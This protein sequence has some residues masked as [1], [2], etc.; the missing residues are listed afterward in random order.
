MDVYYLSR[1][2]VGNKRNVTEER[3]RV[4]TAPEKEPQ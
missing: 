4:I 1:L 2:N 3:L